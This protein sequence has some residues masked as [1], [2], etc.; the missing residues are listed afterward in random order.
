MGSDVVA[1]APP[2]HGPFRQAPARLPGPRQPGSLSEYLAARAA[3]TAAPRSSRR[4]PACGHAAGLVTRPL[5][6]QVQGGDRAADPHRLAAEPAAVLPLS[7]Q[8]PASRARSAFR[9]GVLSPL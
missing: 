2:V 5:C 8:R 3:R 1:P 4:S 9:P 6:G 7:V